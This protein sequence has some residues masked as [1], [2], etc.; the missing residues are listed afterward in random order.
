MGAGLRDPAK[1]CRLAGFRTGIGAAMS[2]QNRDG[3]TRR[4]P[5]R[6]HRAV[7]HTLV[8]A[9]ALWRLIRPPLSV[10]LQLLAA[11]ILLFEEWGWRPLVDALAWLARF[12]VFARIE[13]AIAGLPPYGALV[14]LAL[15]TSILFPLKVLA[16]YL[17]AQGQLVAA[18]LLFVGAKIASTALIARVFLLTRP[19]LM[20]IGWFA[21]AYNVVTPW[22][23]ALFA[24]IRASWAWRYGR[25]VKT[26]VRLEVKQ[27][28][29]RVHPTLI[30]LWSALHARLR[31]LR[32]A[33]WRA[34][35]RG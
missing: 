33:L 25:M 17:I 21:A 27:A 9:R 31:N 32:L 3:L 5:R 13:Q 26:R 18:G 10:A 23:E 7:V 12:R 24:R 11:L 16:L 14:A 6:A 4:A 19:A 30:D 2:A 28:W 15:P 8:A 34:V 20:Q 29:T 1:S 22:K 35:G